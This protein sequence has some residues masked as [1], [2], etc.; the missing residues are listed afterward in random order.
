MLQEL[1]L[2]VTLVQAE[3]LFAFHAALSL[4]CLFCCYLP[5]SQETKSSSSSMCLLAVTCAAF[6][7][8]CENPSKTVPKTLL[9]APH[10]HREPAKSQVGRGKGS[11][12]KVQELYIVPP[13]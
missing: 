2:E 10:L 9:T 11:L 8:L 3:V 5:S 13:H 1:S 6:Y 7:L 12:L 4:V